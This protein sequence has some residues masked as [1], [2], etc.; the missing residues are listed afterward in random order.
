M[1]DLPPLSLLFPLAL[2]WLNV[3]TDGDNILLILDVSKEQTFGFLLYW[4]QAQ[5]PL[6]SLLYKNLVRLLLQVHVH[7][8][9]MPI[10]R[11]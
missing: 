11:M 8:V 5:G 3:S 9:L 4:D 1:S 10:L 2:P 6:K 7:P